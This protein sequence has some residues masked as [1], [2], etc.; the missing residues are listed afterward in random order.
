MRSPDIS[1]ITKAIGERIRKSRLSQNLT[2]KEL[3][4]RSGLSVSM[5]SKIENSRVYPPLSTYAKISSCLGMSID[6]LIINST[7]RSDSISIVRFH[8]RPVVSHGLYIGSP[9]AFRKSDKK[10]EPFLLSYPVGKKINQLYQ[11]DYEEM[12]FV[13]EGRI[14]FRYGKQI[15]VLEK[16][17]CAYFDGRSP[18]AG[19]ALTSEGAMALV[20][21]SR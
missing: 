16:G 20:V 4:K 17:D 19:R 1:D 6:E 3:S 14:E 13:L 10:M 7:Q 21:Q 5:I 8:E 15:F 9:L 18:H 2:L 11:H 12:I